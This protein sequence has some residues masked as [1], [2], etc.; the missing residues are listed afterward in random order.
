MTRVELTE[1][2]RQDLDF[3]IRTRELP[4]PAYARVAR[5]LAPLAFAP[6]A[7]QALTG[8]HDGL[9]RIVGPWRW[10]ALL[11]E[12]IEHDD[13][14]LVVAVLDARSRAAPPA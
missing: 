12:V 6:Y 2:A 9:R 11:Y 5:S 14:V 10:M 7:G 13:L 1:L 4:L 8:R 3:L